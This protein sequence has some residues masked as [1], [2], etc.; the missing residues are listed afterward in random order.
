M[1]T[2]AEILKNWD[3]P[4]S[5]AARE[6]A[7]KEFI[8]KEKERSE[9]TNKLMSN[10][11]YINWLYKFTQDKERFSDDDWLYYPERISKYDRDNVKDLGLFY[12]GVSNYAQQ[13]HIYPTPCDFGDFYKIKFNDFGFEIGIM[14]GQGT[15]FFFNKSILENEKE[16]IDFNDIMTGKKQDNVD[17]INATLD[18]LSNMVVNAYESGVPIVAIINTLDNT[19]R[20]LSSEK[21]CGQ[22]K[23]LT[24]KK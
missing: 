6:E 18:S 20:N 4:E 16:F 17:Y 12:E 1:N 22:G 19:I 14:I 24:R 23:Q 5:K 21:E 7:Y 9:K 13:N 8:I 2:I 10:T 11:E 3:T 15:V